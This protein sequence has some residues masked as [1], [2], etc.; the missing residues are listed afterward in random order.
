MIKKCTPSPTST[1]TDPV[2][3]TFKDQPRLR[4]RT[5]ARYSDHC[6]YTQSYFYIH[7][8]RDMDIQKMKT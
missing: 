4:M 1:Y 3:C 7:G 2:T 8:P 5:N 6:M